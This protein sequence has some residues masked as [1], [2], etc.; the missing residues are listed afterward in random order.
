MIIS[1][2]ESNKK[3]VKID[4][5]YKICLFFLFQAL[6]LF[7]EFSIDK[8]KYF[9]RLLFDRIFIVPTIKHFALPKAP[10]TNQCAG[11]SEASSK[12]VGKTKNCCNGS[13]KWIG[14][15]PSLFNNDQ[16]KK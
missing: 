5:F 11:A 1:S 12:W 9:T 2:V 6:R 4:Y 15:H 10:L 14:K 8:F 3:H 7:E 16:A 13:K